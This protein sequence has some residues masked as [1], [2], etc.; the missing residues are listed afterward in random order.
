MDEAPNQPSTESP[1]TQTSTGLTPNVGAGLACV[2]GIIGGIVFLLIEKK[3]Q[4]IRFWSMQMVVVS[5]AFFVLSIALS[6]LNALFGA[7]PM[8]G[9]VFNFLFFL[10]FLVFYLGCFGLWLAMLIQAFSGKE[11]RMPYVAPYADRFLAKLTK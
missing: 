9:G 10:I 6:I 1:A 7:L 8:I 3:N 5:V 4:F 2:F 11:W